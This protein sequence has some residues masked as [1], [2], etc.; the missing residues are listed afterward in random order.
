MLKELTQ[1]YIKAFSSKDIDAIAAM[2]NERTILEDPVVERVEDKE[3][4]LEAIKSIF[5]SCTRLEFRAKNI[6]VLEP[7]VTIIEF[8]LQLD[9][10]YLHGVDILEWENNQIKELRAYLDIPK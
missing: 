3:N 9:H 1:D 2:L 7:K 8:S 6:Y 5:A 4:V 10:T